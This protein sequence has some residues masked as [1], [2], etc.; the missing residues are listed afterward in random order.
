MKKKNRHNYLI[1]QAKFFP[2]SF[3]HYFI[4]SIFTF[5]RVILAAQVR[6]SFTILST[7]APNIFDVSSKV[8]IFH[9]KS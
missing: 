3:H 9:S 8:T 5:P 2:L 1:I 6:S 7:V 4:S